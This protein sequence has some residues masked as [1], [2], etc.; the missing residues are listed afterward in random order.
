MNTDELKKVISGVEY[1][2]Q[3]VNPYTGE[4][5]AEG[6]MLN[7]IRISRFLFKVS[8]ILRDSALQDRSG[9]KNTMKKVRVCFEYNPELHSQ[10]PIS[11]NSISLSVLIKNIKQAY[12]D[13]CKL[14]YE[15]LRTLLLEKEVL[16]DNPDREIG[17]K[18]V[19]HRKAIM[20][21]A[22]NVPGISEEVRRNLQGY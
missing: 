1:L 14:T 2:T 4:Y 18:G 13:T 5:A 11:P 20:N 22:S 17:G 7:D 19:H 6:D 21:P 15:D 8:V 16:V 10:I 3:G 12:G 9:D